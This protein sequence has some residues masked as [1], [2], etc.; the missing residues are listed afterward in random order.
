MHAFEI[1]SHFSLA[2][3]LPFIF[4]MNSVC[5]QQKHA[6]HSIPHALRWLHATSHQITTN[7]IA[8]HVFPLSFATINSPSVYQLF[9]PKAAGKRTEN[10]RLIDY[11]HKIF[12]EAKCKCVCVWVSVIRRM[13]AALCALT[14][15][16]KRSMRIAQKKGG[17]L[18]TGESNARNE[19][20]SAAVVWPIFTIES[21]IKSLFSQ[22][23]IARSIPHQHDASDETRIRHSS[24]PV[25]IRARTT[26]SHLYWIELFRNS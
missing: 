19:K 15:S 6:S 20:C 17:K 23:I 1:E 12:T 10:G 18:A 2:S 21:T 7:P 8:I 14:I 9:R 5:F 24:G 3:R 11:M 13:C 16:G 4:W 26:Y 22:K 25:W